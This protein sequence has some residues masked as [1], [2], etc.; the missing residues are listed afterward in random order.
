MPD[1][2]LFESLEGLRGTGKSTVAPLLAAA[3]GAELVPTVP[4]LYQSL[5]R[6]IDARDNVEARMAFYLS[7]LFTATDDIH[8]HL[9]A[10]IPVVVDSY[11][12]RCLANHRAYG[13]RLGITLP[14]DLPEPIT[15]SLVCDEEERRRRLLARHKPASR[16][17]GLAEEVAEQITHAY[18]PFPMH[19]VD[20]TGRT[21]EQVVHAILDVTAQ[22][23]SGADPQPVGEHAH[24]LP[25]VPRGTVGARRL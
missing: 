1:R 13:S 8:R 4:A 10:G 9:S 22:G 19:R 23:G 17:D 20:T 2:P 6:E 14:P 12:A 7:A 24:L 21:P 25:P 11:F 3:R 18:A 15:Y 16:W 5:R